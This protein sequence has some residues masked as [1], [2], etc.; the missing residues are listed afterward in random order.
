MELGITGRTAAVAAS[1]AG[2]GLGTAQAL[3]AEGVRVAMC[4]RNVGR[5]HAAVSTIVDAG[6]D[7]VPIEADV[8]SIEGATAF[9]AAAREALGH[10]DILVPNAGGPPIGTFASTDL[11]AYAP[12]LELTLLSAVAM[13]KAVVPDMRARGW[14]RV[15]AITS[16]SVR[17]PIAEIILSNMA[18]TGLTGFLKTLA[19]EVAA[20]GVTVNSVQPGSH[21]TD[22]LRANYGGDLS[23]AAAATPVGE[24][25]RAEDFGAVVAFLCSDHAKF[26]TGV[27]LPVDGG[28]YRGLQ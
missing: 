14:G 21:A 26:I 10:I 24:V 27:A 3:A 28:A 16:V 12:A 1:S 22:R 19:L 8:S 23:A 25:G 11:D 4:G 5:L 13:C 17:Q 9:V 20:D 18:R 7:A 15:V 2:L 6:G